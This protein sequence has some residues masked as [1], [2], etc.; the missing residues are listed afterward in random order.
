MRISSKNNHWLV[1]FSAGFPFLCVQTWW[2]SQY[3]RESTPETIPICNSNKSSDRSMEVKLAAIFRKLWQTDRTTNQATTDRP[4]DQPTDGIP[5]TPSEGSSQQ[6][7]Y[8]DADLNRCEIR[9]EGWGQLYCKDLWAVR[10]EM[11][12]VFK[13]KIQVRLQPP[14]P[15]DSLD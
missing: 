6:E 5:L 11:T 1:R 4:T 3:S 14:V 7:K 15:W 2:Y 10:A 13:K 12:E 9:S 8:G